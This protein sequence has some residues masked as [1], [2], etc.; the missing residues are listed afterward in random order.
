MAV[1]PK[2]SGETKESILVRI[3]E[4]QKKQYDM[5][6]GPSGPPMGT[7]EYASWAYRKIY[8]KQDNVDL[9]GADDKLGE[10]LVG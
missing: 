5:I 8:E 10:E 2:F 1:D 4:V 6:E 3:S 7:S 9:I